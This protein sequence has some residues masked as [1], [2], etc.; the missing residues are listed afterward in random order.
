MKTYSAKPAEVEKKWFVIDAED[1]V[2]GRLASRVA[3]I[4]RGK[5]KAIYTPHVDTGDH[6]IVINA[7]KVKLTGRKYSDRRFYWHTGHPGGIKDRTMGETLE[8][9]F[10]ERVIYK[11]VERMVP[12]GPLGREQLRK[13][14]VYAGNEHPH[15]AQQPEVLDI[16]AMNS[17][18][19]RV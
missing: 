13:L 6:V 18:N 5:H 9:R 1:I 15:E 8:G 7:E 16:A 19:K 12:S 4:L 2:L 10:P 11:A 3:N 14:R 17:K